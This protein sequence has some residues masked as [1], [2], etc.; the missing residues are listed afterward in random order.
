MRSHP[1]LEV[2]LPVRC[3]VCRRTTG[4]AVGPCAG[5][6]A[7]LDPPPA[8][9]PPP[10]IDRCHAVVAYDGPGREVVAALKFRAERAAILWVAT[11]LAARVDVARLDVVTWVP[12]LG[13]RRRRRGADPAELL[14]RAVAAQVGLPARGLLRRIPGPPQAGRGAVA[15]RAGPALVA[16]RRVPGGVLLVDDVV[17]TGGSLAAA[18]RALRATGADHVVAACAART[19]PGRASRSGRDGT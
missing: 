5:C 2:L 1:L 16:A 4:G 15:R 10:G 13:A 14:A 9:P 12:T 11:V 3:P 17:T 7:W 8:L 18:A 19:P 6:A